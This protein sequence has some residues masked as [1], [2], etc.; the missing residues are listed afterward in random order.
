MRAH[1]DLLVVLSLG[2]SLPHGCL[3][4]LV[5]ELYTLT[6]DSLPCVNEHSHHRIVNLQKPFLT[7]ESVVEVL[8]CS[9]SLS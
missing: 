8:A 7:H 5:L 2:C 3:S 4:Y 1:L 6:T 9:L